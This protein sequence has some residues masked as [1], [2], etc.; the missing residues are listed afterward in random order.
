MKTYTEYEILMAICYSTMTSW[1]FGYQRRLEW[2][3]YA[4]RHRSCTVCKADPNSP[5]LNLSDIRYGK[6]PRVNKQPH[7]SRIDWGRLLDGLKER[8]YYRPVIEHQ[9]RRRMPTDD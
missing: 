7:D 4:S 3:I 6:E 2:Q 1:E 8:G 5:C 9:T